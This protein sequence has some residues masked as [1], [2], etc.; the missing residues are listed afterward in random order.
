MPHLLKNGHPAQ[1][2]MPEDRR[3]AAAATNQIRRERAEI[4]ALELENRLCEERLARIEA[5]RSRKAAQ[6][7][8]RW[9][10]IREQ[11]S[12]SARAARPSYIEVW[13]QRGYGA[14]F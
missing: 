11:E 13:L 14:R 6:A 12:D 10:R 3:K 5:R 1:V 2:F 8:A 9:A 7:R 4:V